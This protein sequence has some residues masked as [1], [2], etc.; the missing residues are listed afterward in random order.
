M[1][2]K[3]HEILAAYVEKKPLYEG[4]GKALNDFIDRKLKSLEVDDFL[5]K[6]RAKD[7]QHFLEKIERP[8]KHYTD[9]LVQITDLTGVRVILCYV[10]QIKKVEKLLADEFMIHE[11][12][13]VDKSKTMKPN[14]FGYLSVHYI[15]SLPKTKSKSNKWKDFSGLKA[16]IQIRTSLQDSWATVSHA[17]QYKR[18]TD[19]PDSLKRK[20]FRLAGLFELAD[21]QFLLIKNDSQE[22]N[23]EIEK[24]LK[25]GKKDEVSIDFISIMQFIS[26]STLMATATNIAKTYKML[27]DQ[28]L[29]QHYNKTDCSI[30]TE[31]CARLEIDNLEKLE[32]ILHER[33]EDNLEE[34]LKEI[35]KGR[36]WKATSAF[37]LL[38]LIIKSFPFSFSPEYLVSKY[39]WDYSSAKHI[40]D[41]AVEMQ[42]KR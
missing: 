3:A 31:E 15:I 39:G 16:E 13:S 9:P 23:R 6:D 28:E 24:K 19:V 41:V 37:L 35:A 32:D 33:S 12:Q 25:E 2:L 11:N 14:T 40:V 22:I 38:L 1:Q 30:V 8:G 42:V 4:F 5:I 17:L 10:D 34:Y 29:S 27:G 36:S 7:P 21:E 26:R 20:L 18:E